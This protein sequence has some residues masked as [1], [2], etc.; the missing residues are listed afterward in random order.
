MSNSK[1]SK[2]NEVTSNQFFGVGFEIAVRLIAQT[3][4]NLKQNGNSSIDGSTNST[5]RLKTG[6]TRWLEK[7][8]N[9]T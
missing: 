7:L 6:F 8:R 9:A 1:A 2:D 3:S 4:N 5:I